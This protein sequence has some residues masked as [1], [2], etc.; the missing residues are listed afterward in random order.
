MYC[1]ECD[2]ELDLEGIDYCGNCGVIASQALCG[3]CEGTFAVNVFNLHVCKGSNTTHKTSGD[4]AESKDSQ[5]T[6]VSNEDL[7]LL[8]RYFE[9][10]DES[11]RLELEKKRLIEI[12]F[13][14]YGKQDL[15]AYEGMLIGKVV[16]NEFLGVDVAVLRQNY[17]E[18][19]TACYT[20]VKTQRYIKRTS[21]L[22]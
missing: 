9:L 10:Q 16:I 15:L 8:K 4:K 13:S 14:R 11:R 22:I 17:P 6:E 21:N 19:F 2:S 20:K 1:L 12:L 3:F 5:V 7:G 18:V